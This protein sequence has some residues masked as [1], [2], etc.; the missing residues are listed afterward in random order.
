V[1]LSRRLQ[2]LSAILL[3]ELDA[4]ADGDRSTTFATLEEAQLSLSPAVEDAQSLERVEAAAGELADEA[5]AL[6]M[7]LAE[8][9]G[10]GGR[11]SA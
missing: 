7:R 5:L 6:Q 1:K 11:R 9:A 3:R 2:E 8:I 4:I 10:V